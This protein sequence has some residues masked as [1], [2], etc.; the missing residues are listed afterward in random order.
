LENKDSKFSKFYRRSPFLNFHFSAGGVNERA[1]KHPSKVRTIFSCCLVISYVEYLTNDC[2]ASLVDHI[3]VQA[4]GAITEIFSESFEEH[5]TFYY[6]DYFTN[7]G[8]TI[9][10]DREGAGEGDQLLKKCDDIK[11]ALS[12]FVTAYMDNRI[13]SNQDMYRPGENEDERNVELQIE[14][15]R[16]LSDIGD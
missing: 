1:S 11:K 16:I 7:T 3:D 10:L 12:K 8:E 6:P 4:L 9:R 2:S 5:P 14:I 15:Q 13:M